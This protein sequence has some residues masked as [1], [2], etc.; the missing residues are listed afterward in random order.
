MSEFKVVIGSNYGDEGKGLA[1]R[2]FSLM[3]KKQ[4]KSCLNVLFNGSC[5]RGHT[6]DFLDGNSH[7]FHHFGCGTADGADTY[8]DENF[9]VNPILFNEEY[10]KLKN[11]RPKVYCNP[12]CRVATPYDVMLNRIVEESRGENKHGSCGLGVWETVVR[13]SCSEF[14]LPIKSMAA[15]NNCGLRDYLFRIKNHFFFDRLKEYG[16]NYADIPDRY[17]KMLEA[18]EAVAFNWICDFR[19]MMDMI[20]F[21]ELRGATIC[22]NVDQVVDKERKIK[23]DTVIYE[24]AQGLALD[25]NN[26]RAFPHVSASSTTSEVPVERIKTYFKLEDGNDNV[27]VCYITRSYF[28]RHGAGYLVNECPM[29]EINPWIVDKTNEPNPYQ[30]IIRY[31]KFDERSFLD[32]VGRDMKKAKNSLRDTQ[33]SLFVTHLNYVPF[34]TSRLPKTFKNIYTSADKYAEHTVTKNWC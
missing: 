9:I 33:F 5:Q 26:Y 8:F 11:Y 19:I 27:E 23:Y 24:G 6:V 1:T 16:I 7:V 20:T 18:D 22:Y 21:A 29:D 17:K 13:Y 25:E 14:N 31:G 12:E 15:F 28:T 32:R 3:A 2:Y 30:G 10:A 4:N 34:D